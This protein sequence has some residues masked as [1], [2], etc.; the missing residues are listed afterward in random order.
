MVMAGRTVCVCIKV[1]VAV[2]YFFWFENYFI[3]YTHIGIYKYIFAV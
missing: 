1:S 3:Q 2:W